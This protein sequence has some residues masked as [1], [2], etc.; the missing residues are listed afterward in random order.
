MIDNRGTSWDIRSH[1]G[2]LGG[3]PNEFS[4]ETPVGRKAI[5]PI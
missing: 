3:K 2:D 4:R 1:I 5:P